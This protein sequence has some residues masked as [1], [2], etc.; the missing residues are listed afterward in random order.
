M[1]ITSELKQLKDKLCQCFT[2]K[3][4]SSET[5]ELLIIN[6]SGDYTTGANYDP[7]TAGQN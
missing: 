7:P 2:R 4:E 6:D 3:S 1:G 5:S